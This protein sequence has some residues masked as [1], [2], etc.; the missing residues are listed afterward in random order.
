L[1]EKDVC[2]SASLSFGAEQV[3][4]TE[5][6]VLQRLEWKLAFPTSMDFLVAFSKVLGM[7][8]SSRT[9]RMYCYILELASQSAS[10]Q[11]ISASHLAASSMILSNFCLP[12]NLVR[13]LWPRKLVGAS[14]LTLDELVSDVVQLS[15]TLDL[16]RLMAPQLNIIH[17][18]YRK[19]C[20]HGVADVSIP[21]LTESTLMAYERRA[22]TTT[23]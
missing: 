11:R 13:T 14:G 7:D 9:F 8:E 4:A 3:M 19:S 5:E 17:R 21:I 6:L 23:L 12:D 20:R 10:Y 22:T 2:F 16:I 1:T 15:E 18:R